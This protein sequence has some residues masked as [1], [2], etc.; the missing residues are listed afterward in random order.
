MHIGIDNGLDG[1]IVALSDLPGVAPIAMISM[2]T[3]ERKRKAKPGKP[4]KMERE[5]DTAGVLRFLQEVNAKNDGTTIFHIEQCPRHAASA[6]AMRVMAFSYG[7]LI[8]MLEAVYYNAPLKRVRCGNDNDGWQKALFEG[9]KP[10]DDTKD[11][12]EKL[13]RKLWPS[14]RWLANARCSVA[15]DGMIDAALIG[16]YGRGL[17][18]KAQPRIG[19]PPYASQNRAQRDA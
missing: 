1:G 14:E 9:M 11:L 16:Y 7:K 10:G 4:A 18:Q 8:G 12:A 15:D 19:E 17:W 5:V 6:N 3:Y 2:P 13:A